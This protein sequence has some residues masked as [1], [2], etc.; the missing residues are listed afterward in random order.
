MRIKPTK[1][2]CMMLALLFAIA[3]P[4]LAAETEDGGAKDAQSAPAEE[5]T[6]LES[7]LEGATGVRVQTMCTNC[8][9]ASVSMFGQS[10]ECVRVW[11]DGLPVLGGLGAIYLLSVMPSQGIAKTDIV[12]GAGTVLSGSEAA[13]GAVVIETT[14][15]NDRS[16]PALNVSADFGGLSW[17]GQKLFAAGKAGR[18]SGQLA[19]THAESDGSDPNDD[20]NFDIAAF[21]RDTFGGSV[22]YEFSPR[23]SLRADAVIYR[24]DQEGSKGGYRGSANP[25][26]LGAFFAENITI[27]RDEFGLA[28][29]HEFADF[30]RFT[31]R[32]R[33]STRDQDTA[34]N[35]K[36]YYEQYMTVDEESKQFDARY[37]RT[38]A[39]RHVLTLGAAYSEFEIDGHTSKATALNPD[40]QTLLDR[41]KHSAIY[42]EI[43]WTLP[44]R[45]DLTTGLR[46]DRIDH[47]VDDPQFGT[48]VDTTPDLGS[49]LLPRVRLGW[50]ATKTLGLNLSAGMGFAAPR[51]VFERV[52]CGA[53]VLSN[54]DVPAEESF[55]VLLD[56]DWVPKRW[57]QLKTSLFRRD[58]DNYHQKY[59]WFAFPNYIP[60]YQIVAY[61]NVIVEGAELAIDFRLMDDRLNLGLSATHVEATHDDP[62][63]IRVAGELLTEIEPGDVPY[64]PEDTGAVTLAWNDKKRG[65]DIQLQAQYTG[66]QLIQRLDNFFGPVTNLVETPSFWIYNANFKKYIW[67]N[68]AIYGGVDNISDEY[69][70]WLDDPRYEYNWGALRGRYVYGGLSYEM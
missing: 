33:T 43:G 30:S 68:L 50:K 3:G 64:M 62:L 46:W 39:D 34:D 54:A 2:R 16:E 10:G 4:I 59:V 45:F 15:P 42:A 26:T 40:G 65:L 52:C 63:Q 19:L 17:Q 31:L 41:L 49:K 36:G 24:E 11:Q 12:R 21:D 57:F 8:N 35:S 13:V 25:V 37:E 60:S 51:P 58:V 6:S 32:A 22:S 28:F 38:L 18:W 69:Q 29:N 61:D 55:N 44:K 5:D 56:A 7:A 66:S 53:L 47:E 67:G 27:D 23:T 14:D 20:G 9:V 48:T 70:E 1:F